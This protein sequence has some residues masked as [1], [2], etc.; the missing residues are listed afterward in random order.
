[1][2]DPFGRS[3]SYL[4]V[5]V[6]DRCDFRCVYCMPEHMTFLPKADVLSLEELDRLCSA[7]VR[8]G[9][10]K[11]RLT[12]GEPLVRRDVMK[13]FRSLGRH[14]ATGALCELTLTTNGS[15]LARFASELVDCGVRRINVSVDTLDAVKF[16]TITRW[17]DLGKVMAGLDAAQAAGLKVKINAVALK[18]V[19]EEEIEALIEWAHGRGMGLTLIEVMPLGEIETRRADQFLPLSAVRA[20]LMERYT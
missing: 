10:N 6:T 16:R 18:G 5:S 12:G 3:V 9:V 2:I 11:L 14:V 7:F 8:K 4:R 1:M 20:R 19:N 15:Q 13:L 17:G